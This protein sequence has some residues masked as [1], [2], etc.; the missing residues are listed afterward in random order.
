MRAL[1][2]VLI[3]SALLAVGCHRPPDDDSTPESTKGQIPANGLEVPGPTKELTPKELPQLVLFGARNRGYEMVPG[4]GQVKKT[5]N[6]EFINGSKFEIASITVHHRVVNFHTGATVFEDDVAPIKFF[7][8][9]QFP[10]SGALLP[11]NDADEIGVNV[12]YPGDLWRTDTN[13]A[14]DIV[15][16]RVF[17]GEQDLQ[18]PSHLYTFIHTAKPSDVIAAFKANPA[19]LKVRSNFATT[20]IMALVAGDV[21]TVKY[22]DGKV[23]SVTDRIGNGSTAMNYAVM[24]PDVLVLDYLLSKGLKVDVHNKTGSTP[25]YTACGYGSLAAVEWLLKHGADPNCIDTYTLQPVYTAFKHDRQDVIAA[26]FKAGANP[27][28]H[29]RGGNGWRHYAISYGAKQDAFSKYGIP[30]DDAAKP[31]M[32]TPLMTAARINYPDGWRWLLA[33]GAD[34]YRKNADGKDAFELSKEGNTL[35]SD[36]F[37]RADVAKFY[38]KPI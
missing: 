12:A 19:L 14:F 17:D 23:G 3:A 13:D 27:H 16:I 22:L 31:Y 35:R 26:M 24:N 20:L 37:F 18:Q 4:T 36:E 30:I 10:V 25:L 7:P 5:Y 32:E 6:L 21:E 15:S 33:H 2:L 9:Q 8:N 29:D 1:A 34:P 38:R 28:Y 11:G